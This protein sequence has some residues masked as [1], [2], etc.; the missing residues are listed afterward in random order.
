VRKSL[1]WGIVALGM[2]LVPG[3]A[4]RADELSIDGEVTTPLTLDDTALGGTTVMATIGTDVYSGSSVYSLISDAGFENNPAQAKNGNLLDYLV[5]SGTSGQSVVLS[6]GQIDPGFG[7]QPS[8]P[9][10]FIATTKNGVPIAPVL[11]VP[12][13]PNGL[14][15]GYDVTGVNNISVNWAAVPS[16]STT[17]LDNENTFT[18]TG[19]RIAGAPVTYNTTSFPA[20]FPTS[21]QTTQN[22][23]YQGPGGTTNVQ[24]TGVPIFTLLQ[25]AGLI[26]DPTDPQS[27][28]DDYIVVTGSNE[29]TSSAPFDY[30]VLYSMGEIDPDYNGGFP[31]GTDDP[32][33]AQLANGTFR[34]TAPLDL[35]GGRYDS[36]VINID[37]ETIPEPD[38]LALLLS[39]L[40]L[41]ALV[42][43]RRA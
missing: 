21:G 2:A 34:S 11:I 17:A 5:V 19:N 3:G 28:L 6:E 35:K 4:A 24:F 40:L 12:T 38:S 15:D 16:A 33:I 41:L 23:T 7:G 36:D 9:Q 37:V 20:T 43:R 13:D 1:G 29:P 30:A 27:I 39:P 26:T 22:D 8:N 18:V 25:N 10:A 32:L 31:M 14:T 42:R